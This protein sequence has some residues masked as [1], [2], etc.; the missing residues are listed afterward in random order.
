[1]RTIAITRYA[2]AG[3]IAFLTALSWGLS[4]ALIFLV[5]L[6]QSLLGPI[7]GGHCRFQP[8]CSN[9]AI[10]AIRNCGPLKGLRLS[11]WRILRCHPYS[12]GGYDPAPE[13][14]ERQSATAVTP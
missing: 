14:P 8:T 1:M 7:L 12:K 3:Y 4:A 13:A 9:Y 11:V 6:Y 10:D 2:T 5:R